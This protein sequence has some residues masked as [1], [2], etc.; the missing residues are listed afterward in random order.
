MEKGTPPNKLVIGLA[1]YGRHFT[2]RDQS[3]FY[4]GAPASGA[5]TPGPMTKEAGLLAYYEASS[6]SS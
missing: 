5:G 2:L 6:I 1:T 4:M 3:Q